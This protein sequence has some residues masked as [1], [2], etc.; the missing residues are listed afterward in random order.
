VS[1]APSFDVCL[2][3]L[4]AGDEG[5][6]A[7]VFHRFAHRLIGLARSRLDRLLRQKVDPE[8][9]LQSVF[10]SFF[11]K[12]TEGHFDLRDWDSLWA[13]L[14][15]ITLR[16]C[17]RHLKHFRAARRDVRREVPGTGP[18]DLGDWEAVCREPSPTEAAVL[19]E[20]LEQL[21]RG[22]EGRHRDIVTLRLQGYANPEIA[23]RL[24]C[25]ER[26]IQRVLD[27]V[28]QWLGDQQAAGADR[29]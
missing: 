26:T 17:G 22:L 12:S 28:R 8:D 2:A 7:L 16:K 3:R 25:T 23:A 1:E 21:L 6:A 24:G 18:D 13:I 20:T 11:A 5:A 15:V 27:R 29:V 19:S 14:T 4:R 10:Q 9:V